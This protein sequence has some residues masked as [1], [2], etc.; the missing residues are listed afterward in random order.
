MDLTPTEFAGFYVSK[1]WQV[2]KH[3]ADWRLGAAYE[4]IQKKWIKGSAAV[5]LITVPSFS[6]NNFFEGGRA[7]ERVWLAANNDDISTHPPSLSTLIFNTLVYGEIDAL[8][9]H[10]REEALSLLHE[11][12]KIFEIDAKKGKVLLMRFIISPAPK[13]KSL[14]YPI[15]HILKFSK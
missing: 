12:E 1:D 9:A 14:R 13:F 4:K 11:F 2:V 6:E 3:L 8:P 7:L 10:M 5:G 15:D